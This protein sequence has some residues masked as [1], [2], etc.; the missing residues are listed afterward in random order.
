MIKLSST[1]EGIE[2]A[3]ELE[4]KH[5]I[6]CVSLVRRNQVVRVR[7]AP[8]SQSFVACSV[9]LGHL[10]QCRFLLVASACGSSGRLFAHSAS[11]SPSTG[12]QNLT[13]LFSFAQAVACAEAGVTLI[14]PFVGR[15]MDWHKAKNPEGDF[16]NEK[17]PGTLLCLLLD[18]FFA[19]ERRALCSLVSPQSRF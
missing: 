17:D 16:S 5:G 11:C 9:Q 2:A 1:W 6:H 7:E 18:S 19:R 8:S 14:S 4:S 13:L 15:I 10:S 3:R 12:A